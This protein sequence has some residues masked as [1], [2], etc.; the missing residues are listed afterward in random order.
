MRSLPA[1][2]TPTRPTAIGVRGCRSSSTLHRVCTLASWCS[3]SCCGWL[4]P[5]FRG[6]IGGSCRSCSL[7]SGVEH[8]RPFLS[9]YS[10]ECAEV[11]FCEL[12]LDGVLGSSGEHE[13]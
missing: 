4:S 1:C 10:P 6:E 8:P 5:R 7:G 13:P 11:E 12:R 3:G 2:C 9:P